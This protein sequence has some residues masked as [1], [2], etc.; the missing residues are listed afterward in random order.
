MSENPGNP[1]LERRDTENRTR[2]L[3]NA[4]QGDFKS[5]LFTLLNYPRLLN[6]MPCPC[7]SGVGSPT[8]N[9]R[10]VGSRSSPSAADFQFA[11][12][13]GNL[14]ASRSNLSSSTSTQLQ[15]P[16][17]RTGFNPQPGH[18]RI[19]A[20]ESCRMM[21]LFG[22]FSRDHLFPPPFNSGAV[23]YAPR[24]TLIGSQDLDV[25]SR[26]NLRTHSLLDVNT[27]RLARR[28]DEALGVRVS[29]ARIAPSLLYLERAGLHH[30]LKIRYTRS[31]WL[32]TT[33]LRVPTLNCFSANTPSGNG[34]LGQRS[35]V[36]RVNRR[37]AASRKQL[38][39]L[40]ACARKNCDRL[41]TVERFPT[42]TDT[43]RLP[44]GRTG[45]IPRGRVT[46]GFSRVGILPDDAVGRWVFSGVSRLPR[47]FISAL[48]HAQS[49][50]SALKTSL[51]EPPK[52]H[53]HSLPTLIKEEKKG[54]GDS[55]QLW[56]LIAT[57]RSD[58]K[59]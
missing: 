59:S 55:Y 11:C 3:P 42:Q 14:S 13:A 23:A 30:R 20:S 19:S 33:N 17:R 28:S 10:V 49:P 18:C 36:E 44:P 51:L 40:Q 37:P 50:S 1:R 9:R 39:Q 45:F 46:P 54:G 29:V 6:G 43:A 35:R 21:P 15:L 52:Y 2:V 38:V 47:H 31:R 41:H 48:L 4:S 53:L 32:L 58:S 57:T 7:S 26:P 12:R 5:A 27:A 8:C 34:M 22:G 25:K 24:F 56:S 16:P